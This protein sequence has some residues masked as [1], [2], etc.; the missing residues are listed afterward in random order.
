MRVCPS[1][2]VRGARQGTGSSSARPERSA[3]GSG[4]EVVAQQLARPRA[5]APATRRCGRGRGPRL[6]RR[7]RARSRRSARPRSRRRLRRLRRRIVASTS[8]TIFGASPW[9]GSSNSTNPG[10]PRRAREIAT[11]CISPPERFSASRCI[12]SSIGEKMPKASLRLP[13]PEARALLGDGEFF[14]TVSVGQS[15]RSSG[16]QPMPA[17]AIRCVGQWVT[18][19]PAKR[20]RPRFG[21]VR[22]RIDRKVVVL[23]APFG[24]SSAKTSAAPTASETSKSTCVSP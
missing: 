23:P 10:E 18:S 19:A 9:L 4:R 5:L 3:R 15:R 6:G 20:M 8:D 24:P 22:P 12:R 13:G 14:A 1:S 16:T 21:R 11:I 7:P 17:R 2:G